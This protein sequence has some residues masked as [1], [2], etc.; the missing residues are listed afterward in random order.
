MSIKEDFHQSGYRIVTGILRANGIFVQNRCVLESM[1]RADLE[2]V[3]MRSLHLKT[4]HR[5]KYRVS[6]PGALWHIDTNHK[7]IRLDCMVKLLFVCGR[8]KMECYLVKAFV[9][10]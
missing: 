6:G 8:A 7:I 10:L 2:G 3:I 5:R 4:I 9:Q 1:S